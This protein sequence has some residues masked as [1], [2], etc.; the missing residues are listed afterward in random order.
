[1]H[2]IHQVR[3]YLAS[4]KESEKSRGMKF[5]LANMSKGACVKL[6]SS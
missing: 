2:T 6:L 1:M 5:L 4:N 3:S